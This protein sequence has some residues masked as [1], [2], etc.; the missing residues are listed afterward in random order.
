MET[1]VRVE[2]IPL[3]IVWSGE[4]KALSERLSE[5]END[6][7]VKEWFVEYLT[8]DGKLTG[9]IITYFIKQEEVSAY[10]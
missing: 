10:V 1:L 4:I 7:D 6:L 2:Y 3:P 9:A 8:K 5:L